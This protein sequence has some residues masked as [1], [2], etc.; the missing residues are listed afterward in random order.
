MKNKPQLFCFTHAGGTAEFF[1]P[2]KHETSKICV[3][4]LE[5]AGHGKRHQEGYYHT[6]NELT[7]DML[8]LIHER[9]NGG[10]YAL[11]GYSMGSISLVEV[12]RH[13]IREGDMPLPLHVF[14]AAHEPRV[15]RDLSGFTGQEDDDWVKECTVRFGGIPKELQNNAAFWRVYLPVYR[16][17]YS[18]IGTYNF[19]KLNFSCRIPTTVFYSETDTPIEEMNRWKTYFAGACDFFRYEGNHFFMKEHYK[20]ITRIIEDKVGVSLWI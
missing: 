11:F 20:D 7:D 17:D 13:I 12:M 18:L 2:I 1:D 10:G 16:A 8:R 4:A 5:Y 15:G 19:C 9:Y 14:L 6:F 3:E